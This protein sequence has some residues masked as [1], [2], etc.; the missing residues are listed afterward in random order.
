MRL[1]IAHLMASS[2]LVALAAAT[3]HGSQP[4]SGPSD[5]QIALTAHNNGDG[6]WSVK[7]GPNGPVLRDGLPREKALAIVGGATGPYEPESEQEAVA[8][9]DRADIE[10]EEAAREETDLFKSDAEVGQDP[11]KVGRHVD[12]ALVSENAELR[13]KSEAHAGE[14]KRAD[15]ENADLRLIISSRDEDIRQLREQVAK[16]DGDGDGKT[17]GSVAQVSETEATPGPTGNDPGAQQGEAA[18]DHPETAPVEI[19]ADWADLHWTQRVKL[20]KAISG[21]EAAELTADQANE[22]ITAEVARRSSAAPADGVEGAGNNG[23]E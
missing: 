6:T 19:P 11:A 21:D 9:A 2:A 3:D 13:A 1:H 18:A 20:A 8:A 23:G 12:A 17:G 7:R 14:L 10:A 5:G 22:A 15:D 4:I 16:F